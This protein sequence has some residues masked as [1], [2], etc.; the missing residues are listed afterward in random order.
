M[1]HEQ[2]EGLLALE[3]HTLTLDFGEVGW[4]DDRHAFGVVLDIS[5]LAHLAADALNAHRV[6]ELMLI[7]RPG[8]I[9]DYVQVTQRSIP[10]R[11]GERLQR[12]QQTAA[13]KSPLLMS[14]S[15]AAIPLRE[16]D[17]LFRW[18]W[19]DTDPEDEA[20]LTC[21]TGPR[22]RQFAID[23]L[24]LLKALI[25]GLSSQSPLIAH[26]LS[27]I[28]A[29]THAFWFLS[30][31]EALRR[32][33]EHEPNAPLHPELYYQQL[34]QL[35]SNANIE[36]V[37]YRGGDDYRTFKMLCE[38]QRMRATRAHCKPTHALEIH[39]LGHRHANVSPWQAEI[40]FYEE[41]LGDATLLI[42]ESDMGGGSAKDLVETHHR[43]HSTCF[44]LSRHDEGR[45][46]GFR[47][48]C[49]DGWVL[50]TRE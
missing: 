21:R 24:S 46:Q 7:T 1:T 19:D 40:R 17:T 8:D 31:E 6:Y 12:L 11:V 27:L 14:S 35:L 3:A 18:A 45:I 25:T 34:R 43:L 15:G 38:E 49:G 23:A 29:G 16:F 41:G 36:S 33:R 28:S 48:D 42:D 13:E 10:P 30:R 37:A 5:P 44:I 9:W 32:G 26:E 4:R 2:R 50:Y 20:W 39:A 22:M 47:K